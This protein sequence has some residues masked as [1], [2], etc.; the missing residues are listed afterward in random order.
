MLEYYK[1]RLK[2]LRLEIEE[3]TIEIEKLEKYPTEE[4]WVAHKL[5]AI[6]NASKNGGE[7]AI[8]EVLKELKKSDY[9]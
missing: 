6:L 7:K 8:A 5:H 9:L 1:E 2:S 4:D 3:T